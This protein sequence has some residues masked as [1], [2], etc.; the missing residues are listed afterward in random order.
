[1]SSGSLTQIAAAQAMPDSAAR[2]TQTILAAKAPSDDRAQPST[3]NA[4]EQTSA[5]DIPTDTSLVDAS[6]VVEPMQLPTEM[7]TP[8]LEIPVIAPPAFVEASPI[9]TSQTSQ[10]ANPK[11]QLVVAG[12]RAGNGLVRVAI[13]N[14]SQ[15]FP[16]ANFAARKITVESNQSEV[17][18]ELAESG[19]IAVTVY[20][21]INNDGTLNVNRFGIPIEPFAF[22]NNAMGTRGPPSFDAAVVD[23]S[24]PHN[25]SPRTIRLQLP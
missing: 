2:G 4:T 10:A 14:E 9:R 12:V 16:D 22:S 25:D 21:D 18:T 19:R 17:I 13:F 1:M 20:Q 3:V 23:L 24:G 8:E 6:L 15:G 11:A 7:Q 5:P